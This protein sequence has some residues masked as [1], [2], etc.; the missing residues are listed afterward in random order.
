VKVGK[1]NDFHGQNGGGNGA[2][3]GAKS[4]TQQSISKLRLPLMVCNPILPIDLLSAQNH[5]FPWPTYKNQ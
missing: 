4:N 3:K 2:G 1:N 5:R